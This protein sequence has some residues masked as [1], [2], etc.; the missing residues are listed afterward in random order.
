VEESH[1]IRLAAV[2]PDIVPLLIILIYIPVLGYPVVRI[3][4]RVGYSPFWVIIAFIP[5]VNLIGL[6]VF[7]FANWPRVHRYNDEGHY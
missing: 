2:T 6:W 3:L 7:A 1:S 5:I 4:K